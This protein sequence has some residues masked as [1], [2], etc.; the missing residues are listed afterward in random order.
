MA[1]SFAGNVHGIVHGGGVPLVGHY[2]A[3]C[4]GRSFHSDGPQ[5]FHSECGLP[6]GALLQAHQDGH[7]GSHP[8]RTRHL[9]V[10]LLAADEKIS[11]I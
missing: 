3:V 6:L 4:G 5:L 1:L 2:G 10:P 7:R 9:R 8:A 11:F